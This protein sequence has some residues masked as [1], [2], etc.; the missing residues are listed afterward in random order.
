[1]IKYPIEGKS[2]GYLRGDEINVF[3]RFER[4]F[5]PA[6]KYFREITDKMTRIIRYQWKEEI[7]DG[8]K[9]FLLFGPPGTGKTLLAFWTAFK[10]GIPESNVLYVDF[11]SLGES[12]VGKMEKI[13][14]NM[15]NECKMS[16]SGTFLLIFDDAESIFFSRRF[17]KEAWQYT[18]SSVFLHELDTLDTS[19]AAV[20]VTTNMPELLDPAIKDR[21]FPILVLPS[22]EDL[23][24][25]AK[26]R[27]RVYKLG[28]DTLEKVLNAIERQYLRGAD[29]INELKKDPEKLLLDESGETSK[30]LREKYPSVRLI[31]K[32][33]INEFVQK[34]LKE[35]F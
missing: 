27:A 15:F 13:L 29:L 28:T 3:D 17:A 32:I 5:I 11:G 26:A 1:M 24:E 10:L 21:L 33:V 34:L 30:M 20:I 23:R 18:L 25:I 9:G 19:K 7:R 8:L 2:R 4:G 6:G 22:L 16:P 12:L 14:R 35:P 31:E